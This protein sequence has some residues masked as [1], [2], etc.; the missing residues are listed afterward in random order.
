M[1]RA[2]LVNRALADVLRGAYTT[3][4]LT[5]P[6]L[7]KATGINDRTIQRIMAGAAPVTMGQLE[8]IAL[9]V[10]RDP[11]E[12]FAEALKKADVD[13]MS[14][15]ADKPVDLDTERKRKA[16]AMTAQQIDQARIDRTTPSAATSDEE[17]DSDEPEAP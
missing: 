6:E 10:K 7:A 16:A 8:K 2:A 9:A 15:G 4:R 14:S 17:F 1:N 13:E 11:K 3:A 12:L 5:Q